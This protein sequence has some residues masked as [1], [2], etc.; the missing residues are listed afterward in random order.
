MPRLHSFV[1]A[2]A[3]VWFSS[4]NLA[5]AQDDNPFGDP[6]RVPEKSQQAPREQFD[7]DSQQLLPANPKQWPV[8]IDDM[9]R[10]DGQSPQ[11]RRVFGV[12][13]RG[14]VSVRPEATRSANQSNDAVRTALATPT[15]MEFTEMPLI[16]A[17]AY[18]KDYHGIE[19]QLDNSALESAGVGADTPVTR[20][21]NGLPLGA[22]LRLLLEEYGLTYVVRDGVLMITTEPASRDYLELK[23]YNVAKVIGQDVKAAEVAETLTQLRQAKSLPVPQPAASESAPDTFTVVPFRNLLIVRASQHE[24]EEIESL[25]AE[26]KGQLEADD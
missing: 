3:I 22:S 24:H 8:L 16:D 15:R 7:G 1:M 11:K 26:M 23:V 6:R 19:I 9:Q 4:V 17:V 20:N 25:F 5:P 18:L 2:T 12:S 10:P 13:R 14:E 21:L